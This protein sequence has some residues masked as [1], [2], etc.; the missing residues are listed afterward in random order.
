[1]GGKERILVKVV[2]SMAVCGFVIE[3]RLASLHR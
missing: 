2:A 3:Q 1:M